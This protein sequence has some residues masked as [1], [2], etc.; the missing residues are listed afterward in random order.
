MSGRG[1]GGGG[2]GGRRHADLGQ[3]SALNTGS[4][5]ALEQ[6][7]P[8]L[9]QRGA[10]EAASNA[11]RRRG[12]C[13]VSAEAKRCQLGLCH[14]CLPDKRNMME[15]K[16]EKR[17]GGGGGER[18]PILSSDWFQLCLV[19]DYLPLKGNQRR[20]KDKHGSAPP[21]GGGGGGGAP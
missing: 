11:E 13:L 10:G 1:G 20:G 15:N 21:R 3:G 18:D 6:I 2:R 16:T 14:L 7:S 19:G 8:F 17:G 4:G 5:P 12:F 9:D